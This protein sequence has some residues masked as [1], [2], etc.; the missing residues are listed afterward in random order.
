MVLMKLYFSYRGD[1]SSGLYGQLFGEDLVFPTDIVLG[2][3]ASPEELLVMLGLMWG[4]F[5]AFGD[6]D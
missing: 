1:T 6:L 3:G 2:A 4:I 5:N